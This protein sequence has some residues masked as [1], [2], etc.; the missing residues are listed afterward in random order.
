MPLH[1]SPVPYD[2]ATRETLI[3]AF[4]ALTLDALALEAAVYFAHRACRGPLTLALHPALGAFAAKLG[5]FTDAL[6]EYVAQL[7]G[8]P[9][10]TAEQVADGARLPA[11]PT[12]I[13]DGTALLAAL[14]PMTRAF[15]LQCH[16]VAAVANEQGATEALDLV[17]RV[18]AG[19]QFYGWQFAAM[20]DTTT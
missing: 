14:H 5:E 2:D 9:T 6:P 20:L 8:Q 15:L 16:G 11:F 12:D 4:Q 7:G 17:T 1:L 10:G 3:A 19:T 13:S 18:I